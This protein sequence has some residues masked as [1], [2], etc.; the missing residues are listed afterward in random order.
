MWKSGYKPLPE[1]LIVLDALPRSAQELEL[2]RVAD[3]NVAN[4]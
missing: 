4:P 3:K 2:Q 1:A